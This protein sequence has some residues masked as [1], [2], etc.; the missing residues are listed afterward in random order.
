MAD[1]YLCPR[2]WIGPP[3]A[4][5]YPAGFDRRQFAG[6]VPLQGQRNFGT[7]FIKGS[8]FRQVIMKEQV[9]FFLCLLMVLMA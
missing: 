2:F 9:I 8:I 3:P 1:G 4:S 7:A 5:G 6:Q